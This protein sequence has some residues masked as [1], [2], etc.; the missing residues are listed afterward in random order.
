MFKEEKK[1]IKKAKIYFDILS[2]FPSYFESPLSV[3]ILKRAREKGLIEVRCVDIR[4][5]AKGKYKQVDDRPY[6]G[7]PG[8][9]LMAKPLLSSIRSVKKKGAKVIYLSPQGSRLTAKKCSLLAKEKHLILLCGHYEGIDERVIDLEVDEEISIGD[10]VL[11]SGASA[12]LVL[13]D[14]VSRF[15]PGIIGNEEAVKQ[16]SFENKGFFEAPLF[17]RPDEIEGKKVPS[18]LLQGNHAKIAAWRE[19][20]AYEKTKRVRPDLIEGEK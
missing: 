6:G 3:S 18:I 16:D 20:M 11:T 7:G 4:F 15:I 13:L 8:M 14:A 12:A 19:K 2:L 10:F 5:F 1:E 17:T 9:V